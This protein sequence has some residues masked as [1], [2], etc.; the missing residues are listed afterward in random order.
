M[1]IAE[2]TVNSAAIALLGIVAT[3]GVTFIFT[4]RSNARQD[5]ED[6]AEEHRELLQE[7][8]GLK[9]R[10]ATVDAQIVPISTA[11]TQVLVAKLTHLHTPELDGL[12]AKIG[13]P[14]TLSSEEEARMYVLLRR[15]QIEVDDLIPEDERDAAKIFPVVLRM[16]RAE[17][18]HIAMAGEVRLTIGKASS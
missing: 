1:I 6:R 2:S 17:Q 8:A 7:V 15:R 11:F 10:L 16:A 4:Q 9:E 14:F 13:P 18:E 12:L 3:A 5:K